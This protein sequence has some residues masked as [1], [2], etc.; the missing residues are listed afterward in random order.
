MTKVISVSKAKDNIF[1][2]VD[3]TAQNHEPI[4]ITG[5]RNNA[6]MISEEDYRAI[7]E[8]LYLV[9]IPKMRESIIDGLNTSV[10]ECLEELEW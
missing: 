1:S 3:E 2:L 9:S 7:E 10:E 8:T 5:E 4:L 6:V